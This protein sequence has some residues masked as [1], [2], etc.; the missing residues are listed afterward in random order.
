MSSWVAAVH[1]HQLRSGTD[2]HEWVGWFRTLTAVT[3]PVKSQF[4][5]RCRKCVA[6]LSCTGLYRFR[7]CACWRPHR[8]PRAGSCGTTG[9]RSPPRCR[10]VCTRICWRRGSS[11]TRSSAGT[12]PR[13]RGWGGA[14]WT[15]E[16]T[17]AAR[18]GRARADG[19]GL[20]RARHGRRDRAGRPV[21]GRVRNMHRSLPL[22]RHG[23]LETARLSVR[24]TSAYTEAEAVRE[25]ARR[26]AERLSRAV[27]VHPQDGLLLRLG[28]GTDLVTAGIWKPVRLERWSTA[29]L[30]RGAPAGDRRRRHWAASRCTSTSSGPGSTA[31]LARDG[32]GSADVTGGP[33]RSTAPAA[34]V[35]LD[36][37]DAELWWPRGYG[38][39]PLY[40]L[41][42]DAARRRRARSTPGARRIGFRTVELDTERRR[43]RHRLHLRR[44]RRARS[45]RAAP[46]G[47]RTTASR[48]GSPA[49]ATAP[50]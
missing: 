15:Y 8:S 25:R 44:Q 41:R 30:A 4:R 33:R 47:S 10:A 20:R 38:E 50:G 22:R 6:G 31:A 23:S 32:A 48:P 7:E 24:F 34:V 36:V 17:L 27:P 2:E 43:A 5:Q 39:Q 46:T 19:P 9:P 45:S 37:P 42:V 11:R 40:D 35:R 1:L 26:A 49:S 18:P 21:L 16:T 12:R 29:R 3:E 13:W 14:D 28:L